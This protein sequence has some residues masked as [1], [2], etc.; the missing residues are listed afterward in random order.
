MARPK[1]HSVTWT[2]CYAI[3]FPDAN[4]DDIYT[5]TWFAMGRTAEEAKQNFLKE[6]AMEAE[7]CGGEPVEWFVVLNVI[8]GFSA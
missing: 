5:A 1:K 4:P 2:I 6:K 7:F 3:N 8:E